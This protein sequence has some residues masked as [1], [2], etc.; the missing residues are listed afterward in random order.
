MPSIIKL[1]GTETG[2]T[3][4]T[5][6]NNAQLIRVYATANSS[7]TITNVVANTAIGSFT[8]PGGRVEY[9]EKSAND[10]IESDVEVLCTPISYNT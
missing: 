7:I 2:V 1:K 9:V 4:A 10:T 8:V 5:T 3:S 6:L